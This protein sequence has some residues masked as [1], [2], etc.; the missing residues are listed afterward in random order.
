[1]Y[2]LIACLLTV[3]I[4]TVFLMLVGLNKKEQI[5]IIICVNIVSNI[6]LNLVL[7]VLPLDLSY[8]L[9][10]WIA[11]L[12]VLEATVVFCEYFVYRGAFGDLK[13]LFL[14]TFFANMLSLAVGCLLMS[15]MQRA[16]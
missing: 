3:L 13:R 5:P 2:L 15:L 1:M 11:A 4:E 12:A 6:V 14:K 10:Q 16:F 7:M 8:H 9:R